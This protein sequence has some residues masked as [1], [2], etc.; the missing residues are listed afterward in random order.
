MQEKKRTIGISYFFVF[1]ILDTTES[2]A[3]SVIFRN[4]FFY[5]NQ[6]IIYRLN[7][8]PLVIMSLFTRIP[9]GNFLT[10][11]QETVAAIATEKNNKYKRL[12]RKV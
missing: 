2:F 8:S 1:L 6:L 5:S 12:K 11:V 3:S 7:S 9:R 4:N 10:K